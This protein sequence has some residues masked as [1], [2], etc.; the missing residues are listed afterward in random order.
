MKIT[1]YSSTEE[2]LLELGGRIK[3][4]RISMNMTQKAMSDKTNLSLHTISN[5]ENGRDVSFSTIISIIRALGY[6]QVFEQLI[7]TQNVR[8][9]QY[10]EFGKK[11][12]RA[13]SVGAVHERD[14]K[15]GDEI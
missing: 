13:S 6:Q 10:M 3:D 1:M 7:P 15:W 12:E 11:R 5:V 9:S 4:L 8:P 2:V 14:W